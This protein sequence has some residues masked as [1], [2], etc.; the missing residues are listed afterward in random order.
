MPE[1]GADVI[2]QALANARAIRDQKIL[3]AAN[4]DGVDSELL[5]YC[6]LVEALW[7]LFERAE[8]Q[9]AAILGAPAPKR[10]E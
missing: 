4:G 8:R 6:E 2:G 9:T 10:H 3:R 5:G 7:R 1:L